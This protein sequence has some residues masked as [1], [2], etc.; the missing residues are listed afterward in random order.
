MVHLTNES[1]ILTTKSPAS[2]TFRG[3]G[4]I[5]FHHKI[6]IPSD[7]LPIY[8]AKKMNHLVAL[9]LLTPSLIFSGCATNDSPPIRRVSADEFMRPHSF[10][11]IP[12]D[13]FIGTTYTG[14]HRSRDRKQDRAFKQ[15]WDTGLFHSWAV[16]W[17]PADELPAEYLRTASSQPNRPVP[18]LA[19]R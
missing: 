5:R 16:I 2:R 14:V 7:K 8:P 1:Y 17:C 13:Q 9:A 3:A 15:V 18:P 10:K 4:Q 11:G 12:T 6:E 19:P